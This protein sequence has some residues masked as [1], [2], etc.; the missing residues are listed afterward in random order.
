MLACRR[1]LKLLEHVLSDSTNKRTHQWAP[2]SCLVQQR[3]SN[4]FKL[5]LQKCR[6][7]NCTAFS[8]LKAMC[9]LL[10]PAPPASVSSPVYLT[11]DCSDP[12]NQHWP[13]GSRFCD[14]Y[15]LQIDS[16]L[17]VF[18][19]DSHQ[20]NPTESHLY[21]V[22]VCPTMGLPDSTATWPATV[23]SLGQP[24]CFQTL[25]LCQT[26]LLEMVL[27]CGHNRWPHRLL[28]TGSDSLLVRPDAAG[29]CD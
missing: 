1:V 27:R 28:M 18:H 11:G 10:Q 3:Q 5:Y 13:W 15:V 21:V 25:P 2:S 8:L 16:A 19:Y 4:I 29:C 26:M 7:I 17:L 24:T 22:A 6:R 9:R 23:A 20:Q 14:Y 12:C